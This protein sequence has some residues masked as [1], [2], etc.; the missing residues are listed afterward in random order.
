M[1]IDEE[2]ERLHKLALRLEPDQYVHVR[3]EVLH[4]LFMRL[5]EQENKGK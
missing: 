4:E 1:T 5:K 2:L 3:V